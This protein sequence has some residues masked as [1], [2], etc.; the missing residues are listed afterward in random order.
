MDSR[1]RLRAESGRRPARPGRRLD[2]TLDLELQQ[3]AAVY[4]EDRVGSAVVMDPDTGELLT[5][6]SAPSYNPNLFA[7]RLDREQWRQLMEAPNDPLQ[8]RA[9]QNTYPPG[10]VFKIVVAVAG[11]SEAEVRPSETVFCGGAT[12]IYNLCGILKPIRQLHPILQLKSRVMAN[13]TIIAT[14]TITIMIITGNMRNQGR[15]EGM[16]PNP[17]DS[18]V[19]RY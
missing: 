6:V 1:G 8:N 2:L 3:E 13:P 15:M 12:R 14:I 5:L 4:F 9:L 10:S 16:I 17:G 11:L 18:I 7:R 19:S